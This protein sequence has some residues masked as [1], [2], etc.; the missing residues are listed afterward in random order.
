MWQNAHYGRTP[1]CQLLCITPPIPL[2]SCTR[3]RSNV[4]SRRPRI[5]DRS[6]EMRRGVRQVFRGTGCRG[7]SRVGGWPGGRESR[8][9]WIRSLE[10]DQELVQPAYRTRVEVL[11]AP[12]HQLV[13]RDSRQERLESQLPFE[14][15]QCGAQTK[16]TTLSKREMAPLFPSDVKF[17]RLIESPLIPIYRVPLC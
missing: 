17:V 11:T 14:S 13:V 6:R 7:A 10:F 12:G 8:S 9:P 4:R 5:A 3:S 2:W 1:Y 15:S 16:V